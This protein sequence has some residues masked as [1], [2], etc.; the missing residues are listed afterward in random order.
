M[1]VEKRPSYLPEV[2]HDLFT[3]GSLAYFLDSHERD[4]K[5]DRQ[6][7]YDSDGMIV[8]AVNAEDANIGG[9]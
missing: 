7:Q 6:G 1:I 3:P 2:F 8:A 9:S 4:G 5:T